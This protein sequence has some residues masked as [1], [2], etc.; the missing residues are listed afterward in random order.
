MT[1]PPFETAPSLA[2]VKGLR[3]GF[4]GRRHGAGETGVLDVSESFSPAADA[5]GNRAAAMASAGM[6]ALPLALLTQIHSPR[7]VVIDEAPAS[8]KRP[9]ADGLVTARPG[10]ALGIIT[11]DCSPVL[12]CDPEARVIGACHAGWK[13]AVDGV[14][15]NT[16][17][18]M[19]A[20]GARPERIL[21]AFGPTIGMAS[22]EVG[23][24]FAAAARQRDP[25]TS[26]FLAVPPG[27]QR[28]HF[29]LPGY[30]A[31]ALALAGVQS[32]AGVGTCTYASPDKYFSHRHVTHHGGRAGR[33]IALI[34]FDS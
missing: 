26:P 10:V 4:F 29:D 2:G 18:A 9:E 33:Q 30:V 1:C 15:G 25:G 11:A 31:R 7:V 21:A 19:T 13:G 24:D 12:L 34:G 6:E 16:L 3:H 20:L 23:P 17:A 8:G 5:A 27:G 32:V 28:E 14:I 22:Y